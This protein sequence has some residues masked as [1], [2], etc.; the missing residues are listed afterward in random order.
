MIAVKEQWEEKGCEHSYN[1]KRG[2]ERH[3]DNIVRGRRI[4]LQRM[5]SLS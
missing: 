3:G 4:V 2:R 5:I 1:E